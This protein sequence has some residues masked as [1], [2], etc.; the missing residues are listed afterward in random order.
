MP[1]ELVQVVAP[2]GVRLDGALHAPAEQ[3]PDLDLEIDAFICLHGTGSNFYGSSLMAAM[4]PR[5]LQTGA[6]VLAVNTRGHDIVSTALTVDGRRLQGA[7]YEVVDE[8]R[9]DV[10]A[11]VGFLGQR[12]VSRLVVVGHSLGAVKAVYSLAHELPPAVRALVAVSP[13]RLSHSHFLNCPQARQFIDEYELAE[14]HLAQGRPESLMQ[15]RFPLA[16]LVT[17]AGYVDKYGPAERYNILKYV[18]RIACPMLITFGT[19]ELQ[20]GVA[21]QG[22][23]ESLEAE[24]VRGARLRVAIVPGADHLYTGTQAE[25][26]ERIVVWLRSLRST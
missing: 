26:V 13:P 6:S 3:Q 11:W 8:C 17:A 18:N 5:L 16:Y 12:G 4:L 24:R 25:L 22:L 7:A 15:V 9:H 23:P 2:D 14:S 20:H 21:F 10:A 19:A 1:V